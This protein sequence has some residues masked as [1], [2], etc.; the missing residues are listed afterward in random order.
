MPN[1]ARQQTWSSDSYDAHARFVSDLAGGVMEWL[2]PK[3]GERILDLGCGDGVLTEKLV[4]TGAVVTGVDTSEDFLRAARARGLNV[5][6]ID[7][8]ALTFTS[9]F[10]AVFSNAALHWMT[11]AEAVVDG[12]WRALVP[13]GRFVAEFGGHGNVAAIVTAMKAVARMRR[14]G[15]TQSHP[16]FFPTPAIYQRMLEAKGFEVKRI[17]LFP[18]PT[19]LP[20]GM[21]EWLRVFREPFFSQFGKKAGA[22][23]EDTV[24]LLRPSLCD[25]DGNWTAD[26]VRLRVEAVKP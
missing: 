19:I 20:T 13:G 24:E 22:A 10:E 9:S 8:Q 11:D 7:G 5:W 15:D 17:G 16:W 2:Q 1:Q 25:N 26:Y 4:A 6:N 14:I 18:R 23:L 12:V 21:S 3:K